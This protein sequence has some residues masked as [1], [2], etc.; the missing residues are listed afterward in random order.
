MMG[1]CAS[2]SG[3]RF[4]LTLLRIKLNGGAKIARRRYRLNVIDTLV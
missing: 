2:A 4:L 3:G 1:S